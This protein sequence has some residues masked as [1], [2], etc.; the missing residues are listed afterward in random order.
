M[1]RY[2]ADHRVP[3]T[4]EA[5]IAEI[6]A[7]FQELTGSPITH[8]ESIYVERFSHGGMSSGYVEPEFWRDEAILLLRARY[9]GRQVHGQQPRSSEEM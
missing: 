6:E 5:L 9:A 7:A 2:F 3:E 1:E 8:T 4:E